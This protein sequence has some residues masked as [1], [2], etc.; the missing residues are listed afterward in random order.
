LLVRIRKPEDAEAWQT[1]VRIYA[2]LVFNYCR[3]RGLQDADATDL[4]QEVMKEIMKSIRAFDY[5]P[6]KGRFRDWFGLIVRREL[7][8]YWEKQKRTGKLGAD[9]TLAELPAGREDTAWNEEA[10]AQILHV[11]LSRIRENFEAVTWQAFTKT[12]LENRSAAETAAQ[13]GVPIETVYVAKSRVLKRLEDE[14][15][16]LAE[17]VPS[18]SVR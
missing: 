7:M 2:P 1:F 5:Q 13:L 15:L 12:W 14:V 4:T 8:R 6:E 9:D 16:D 3:R 17:D 10:H 11:A 18:P